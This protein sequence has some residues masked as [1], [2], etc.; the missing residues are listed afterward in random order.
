M[1][2]APNAVA[3]SAARAPS[4][5]PRT[6]QATL[7]NIL[8]DIVFPAGAA[9]PTAAFLDAMGG[10]GFSEPAVRQAIARCASSGWI[11]RERHGRST[12][13]RLT[14]RGTALVQEGIAGVENLADPH[15]GW[16]GRWR[17]AIITISNE[18]RA[19]RDRV[20]RALRWDG[21]GNPLPSV[22][23]SPHPQRHRRSRAVLDELGLADS[24]LSFVGVADGIGLDVAE[25]VRR[26]WDLA[27]LAEL[28]AGLVDRFHAVRPA[29]DA[30]HFVALLHLDQELQHLLVTDPHIPSALIPAWPGRAA[31]ARLLALR[32]AWHAPAVRHWRAVVERHG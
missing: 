27:G 15:A 21:F 9:T 6:A 13:W 7:L 16:D 14:A 30:E 26:G 19:V 22:W 31:A 18:Q 8:G 29:N 11:D 10:L 4:P 12:R 3:E 32:R 23:V 5:A 24:T 20:Y 17:I 25:I 28:Y 1:P 2:S